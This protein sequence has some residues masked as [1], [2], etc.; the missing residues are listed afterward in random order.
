M[1]WWEQFI[2]FINFC[3]QNLENVFIRYKELDY[4]NI[5]TFEMK[6]QKKKPEFKTDLAYFG[7]DV[8]RKHQGEIF[9][10][11]IKKIPENLVKDTMKKD[12]YV[13]SYRPVSDAENL[14]DSLKQKLDSNTSPASN[15]TQGLN[16][17]WRS[18]NINNHSKTEMR[19]YMWY[20]AE[21]TVRNVFKGTPDE[22][23]DYQFSAPIQDFSCDYS[24]K[25]RNLSPNRK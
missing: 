9:Q 24:T 1:N 16:N 10:E 3:L 15:M 5:D 22:T 25:N 2:E 20:Q 14:F 7:E 4:Y 21:N 11:K 19:N 6:R 17:I 13:V 18:S 23:T 12:D 8:A